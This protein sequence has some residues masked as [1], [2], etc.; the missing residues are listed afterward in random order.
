[1][2]KGNTNL[3]SRNRASQ[4]GQILLPVELLMKIFEVYAE[5]HPE[6]RDREVEDL[7]LVNRYWNAVANDTP[8]L[9]TKINISFPSTERYLAVARKRVHASKH[10]KIDVAIHFR[11]PDRDRKKINEDRAIK[12]SDKQK[13]WFQNT[14][15]LLRDTEKRWKSVKVVSQTWLPLYEFMDKWTLPHLPSLE[16]ISMEGQSHLWHV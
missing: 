11:C 6:V 10:Q 7:R 13:V 12:L 15:S 1:M 16:S 5:S 2:N 14:M 8:H 9:W 3:T 4:P